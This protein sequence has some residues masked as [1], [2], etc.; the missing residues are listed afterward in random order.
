MNLPASHKMMPPRY[1][2]VLRDSIPEV[3]GD[4]GATVKVIAGRYRGTR[5]PV[6]DIVRPPEY[7]DVSVPPATSWPVPATG[8]CGSSSFRASP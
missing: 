6:R 1:R 7:L 4:G 3:K 2:D 8:E 5:G